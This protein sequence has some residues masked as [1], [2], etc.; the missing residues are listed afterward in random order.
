[1]N[2]KQKFEILQKNYDQI[3]I[4]EN[5]AKPYIDLENN[6]RYYFSANLKA[7]TS[8]L[9]YYQYIV[10]KGIAF[11]P[12][13]WSEKAFQIVYNIS[14]EYLLMKSKIPFVNDKIGLHKKTGDEP[15][16]HC[17]YYESKLFHVDNVDLI[18]SILIFENDEEQINLLLSHNFDGSALIIGTCLNFP[19]F[20]LCF[21]KKVPRQ[22]QQKKQPD[23]ELSLDHPIFQSLPYLDK[24]SSG[25]F[26][27]VSGGVK[28][29][30][31]LKNGECK[32]EEELIINFE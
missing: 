23:R 15:L 24:I 10:E 16:K 18:P 6:K 21:Y 13:L 4:D 3:K 20:I 27:I 9:K 30:F 8:S 7:I 1:M 22:K 17:E 31:I 28:A 12:L 25:D 29:K 32:E 19:Y 11:E 14:Q 5:S 2:P 26:Q